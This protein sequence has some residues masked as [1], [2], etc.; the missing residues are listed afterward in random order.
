VIEN[1]PWW[2]DVVGDLVEILLELGEAAC[3]RRTLDFYCDAQRA[4]RWQVGAP[5]EQRCRALLSAADGDLTGALSRLDAAASAVAPD[6]WSVGKGRTL[7]ARGSL[8][9]V[10]GRTWDGR[11]DLKRALA[12]FTRHGLAPWRAAALRALVGTV[13]P[14]PH[15]W[16][17]TEPSRIVTTL[18]GGF[19]TDHEIAARLQVSLVAVQR[20]MG[21]PSLGLPVAESI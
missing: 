8:L 14:E 12:I 6:A 10:L 21:A 20:E 7:L 15:P 13:A 4:R 16:A 3:A 17:P 1:D 19:W 11:S 9:R 18:T 2:E 5:A